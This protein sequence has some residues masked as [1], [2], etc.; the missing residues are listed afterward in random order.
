MDKSD[1]QEKIEDEIINQDIGELTVSISDSELMI[2]LKTN[3]YDAAYTAD[4][5][6]E[7]AKGLL[8]TYHQRGLGKNI[9]PTAYYIYDLADVVDNRA[10][11]EDVEQKWAHNGVVGDVQ[12]YTIATDSSDDPILSFDSKVDAMRFCEDWNTNLFW[13]IN[14]HLES[15]SEPVSIWDLSE[16]EG[17]MVANHLE[18]EIKRLVSS[19][20][21]PEWDITVEYQPE[22]PSKDGAERIFTVEIQNANHQRQRYQYQI[23]Y[24]NAGGGINTLTQQSVSR[25]RRVRIDRQR[26]RV[27]E[28]M[29]KI[30]QQLGLHYG[31]P[32]ADLEFQNLGDVLSSGE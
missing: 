18:Q 26:G 23:Y 27:L 22:V 1:S 4:E 5:A 21:V 12:Q 8:S 20:D 30:P 10:S 17:K 3:E 2:I 32:D 13:T 24:T 14:Y 15:N 28:A 11:V 25:D 6:R 9:V 16:T 19:D 7:L 31:P 29:S